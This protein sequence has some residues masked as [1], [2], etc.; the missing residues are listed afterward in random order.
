[1]I[2]PALEILRAPSV[3]AHVARIMWP[4]ISPTRL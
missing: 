1:V 4:H 2:A 3:E